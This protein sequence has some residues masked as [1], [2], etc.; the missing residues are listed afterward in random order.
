MK[1]LR[2]GKIALYL[3]V[4]LMFCAFWTDGI[5][6]GGQ[7]HPAGLK[8]PQSS[9]E[10]P[11]AGEF[12]TGSL[13]LAESQSVRELSTDWQSIVVLRPGRLGS[14][15]NGYKEM[16]LHVVFP[17]SLRKVTFYR[18]HSITEGKAPAAHDTE[19]IVCYIHNKDGAK[20]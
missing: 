14:A 19:V 16:Q 4:I 18:E 7:L 20:G 3:A 11:G 9:L 8:A 1:V 12:F 10:Y 13:P 6:L 15:G 2:T 5:A 17:E